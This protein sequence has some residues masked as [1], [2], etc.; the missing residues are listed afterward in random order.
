MGLLLLIQL[1]LPAF[2][3]FTYLICVVHIDSNMHRRYMF[4]D[5]ASISEAL[6]RSAVKSGD[7]YNQA[8]MDI[9]WMHR[10]VGDPLTLNPAVVMIDTKEHQH[11]QWDQQHHNPRPLEEF[12][13]GDHQADEERRQCPQAI[14]QHTAN[15]SL[16]CSAHPPPVK[17]HA[18]L[19]ECKRH[20]QTHSA[21]VDHTP[22][23][24]I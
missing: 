6:Y 8:V 9:F 19:R 1:F 17:H 12:R 21:E 20:E 14:Y 2:P 4:C 7:R 13:R 24:T 15:P 11:E 22:G 5:R 18:A 3:G 16:V 10:N 23:N